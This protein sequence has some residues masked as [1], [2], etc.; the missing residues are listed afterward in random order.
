ML[1]SGAGADRIADT[2]DLIRM[3]FS[4]T[5]DNK[6]RVPVSRIVI[7]GSSITK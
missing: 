5:S 1:D 6:G 2:A 4:M 7:S 3:P